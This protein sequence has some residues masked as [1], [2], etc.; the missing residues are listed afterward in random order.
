[1][2]A[3]P[4]YDVPRLAFEASQREPLPQCALQYPVQSVRQLVGLCRTLQQNHADE[5]GVW[6][7]GC[8]DAGEMIGVRFTLA[9]RLLNRLMDDGI[10]EIIEHGTAAKATRYK[11]LGD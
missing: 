1:L 11:Y 3:K 9:A 4:G 10:L 5:R 6:Y 2:W 7:L 8:R